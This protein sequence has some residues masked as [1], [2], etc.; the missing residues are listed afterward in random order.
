MEKD[1]SGLLSSE[2]ASRIVSKLGHTSKGPRLVLLSLAIVA[3]LIVFA[4][5]AAGG[6]SVSRQL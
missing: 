1:Q 2:A 4:L 3:A 5:V 6:V